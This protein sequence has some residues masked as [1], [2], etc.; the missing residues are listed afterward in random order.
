MD[1]DQE[2]LRMARVFLAKQG[3][4]IETA[5]SQK[6]AFRYL[7]SGFFDVVL[8]SLNFKT[9]NAHRFAETLQSVWPLQ[10]IILMADQRDANTKGIAQS[11]GI[12]QLL[13]KP[14]SVKKLNK[15]VQKVCKLPIKGGSET[16]PFH[17]RDLTGELTTLK[18][19]TEQALAH[20]NYAKLFQ[21][22]SAGL[23][24]LIPCISAGVLGLTDF[25]KCLFSESLYTLPEDIQ[26]HVIAK[27]DRMVSD[28]TEE[29]LPGK[30]QK[31]DH[32]RKETDT[33][34]APPSKWCCL[35]APVTGQNG[36][37]E[38]VTYV[39]L[40]GTLD[41]NTSEINALYLASHHLSTLMQA[42]DQTRNLSMWDN[43]TGLHSRKFLDESLPRI[44][45]LA[46]HN[47]HPL[48]ILCIDLDGFTEINRRHGYLIGDQ[49]MKQAATRMQEHL[50][51]AD[52]IVRLKGDRFQIL[53]TNPDIA[54]LQKIAQ[55][56]HSAICASPFEL[57]S[58]SLSL[59]ATLA[60]A[61]GGKED[62]L[63]SCQQLIDCAEQ[64]LLRLKK[65]GGNAIAFCTSDL[66]SEN[67]DYRKHTLLLVDDDPQVG[68]LITKLLGKEMVDITS[69]GSVDEAENLLKAGSRFEV[70]LTDITMPGRDGF[71]M[72]A[73]AS[74][75]DPNM[76]NLV[77]SGN[78]SKR[79]EQLLED[80]G[81]CGI[82][83][84]PFKLQDA[85]NALAMGIEIYT[86]RQRKK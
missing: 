26:Q 10:N 78:I 55:D 62:G 41:A 6:A 39:V 86:S 85:R 48:G 73:I 68:K 71:D 54:S 69:V 49:V 66:K 27:L 64:V 80:A 60:G 8:L 65:E 19:I 51:P 34:P 21:E 59:T 16:V 1:E 5:Q 29:S 46:E 45:A 75:L 42:I 47:K 81:S 61:M 15:A 57:P 12:E 77:T 24:T 23:F 9:L 28:L 17:E 35:A 76:V 82:L 31:Q 74:R 25:Y 20:Q 70:M 67:E 22:F 3:Y 37:L 14:L 7:L 50:S 56:I 79:T 84:K 4:E 58:C 30:L 63:V 13:D 72:L 11:L 18:Q 33:A 83:R 38:A 43:V 40:P 36:Q 2:T 44:W 32:L 53:L 52:L